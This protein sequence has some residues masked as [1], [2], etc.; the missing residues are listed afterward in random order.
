MTGLKAGKSVGYILKRFPVLSETFVLNEILALEAR[1]IPIHIFSLERPNDPRFHEDLSKLKACIRYI[2]GIFEVKSL[3]QQR[4]QA[5][6]FFGRDHTAVLAYVLKHANP[7]LFWRYLQSCF[8]ANWAKHSG[9]AHFHAHFANRP[10][11]LALLCSQM[12]RIPYSFTAHAVDI[13]SAHL[14]RKVLQKKIQ[15][16]RFVVAISEFNRKF[17]QDLAPQPEEKIVKIYNGIHLNRFCQNGTPDRNPFIFLCVARFVEKKGHAVL[18]KA[19]NSLRERGFDFQCWLAGRGPLDTEIEKGIIHLNLQDH[20]KVL[21][22]L[23]QMEVLERHKTSHAF[24]LPCI[25]VSDGNRDGL[26]V[27]I[28]E[29]LASGRPVVTTPVS[30]IPELIRDQH[31]GIL[32]SSHDSNALADAM[33]ALISDAGLYER[34]KRNTRSSVESE[35]NLNQTVNKLQQLFE[36]SWS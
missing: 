2:P 17:L 5:A 18:L 28:V 13:F 6:A 29:A 34:L 8:V 16:A 22:P 27:S 20:V 9:V 21:G 7:V 11:T 3:L 23:T 25:V 12:T 31:N 36:Q 4:K 30:G 33:A 35:F 14:S 15:N 19:C 26:P 24:V 1:G 32:V 10:T